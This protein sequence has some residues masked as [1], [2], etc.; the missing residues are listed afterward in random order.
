[1]FVGMRVSVGAFLLVAAA[2]WTGLP[3]AVLASDASY[4]QSFGDKT[5]SGEKLADAFLDVLTVAG[6]K[7]DQS[8]A[9]IRPYLDP[10][11]VLQRASGKRYIADTY[12]PPL[13][14]GYEIADVRETRPAPDVMVVRYSVRT[15]ETAPD[16][17]LVM[18]ADKAPR[19]TVFHWH[20]AS[21]RWQ[22][23]SHANFN[24]PVAAVCDRAAVTE[25]PLVSPASPEDYKAGIDTV[26]EFITLLENGDAAPIVHPL[27]QVQTA[28][29]AGLTTLAERKKP[30]KVDDMTYKDPI[31]TRDG[32]VMVF[33]AYFETDQHTFMNVNQLRVGMVPHL[34][35]FMTDDAGKWKMI[36]N[37]LFSPPKDLP[38]GTKCQAKNALL[39]AP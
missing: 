20:D 25:T 31:V 19:I 3:A 23:V 12:V 32:N 4:D 8:Q 16:T 21:S 30:S 15:Q 18:G 7:G 29:G 24:T 1:M 26:D 37:A 2:A 36:A 6:K 35:T 22:V 5:V 14:E 28:S 39:N 34:L 38:E 17:A 13:I 33:S 11:F 9:F 27:Y 10:A